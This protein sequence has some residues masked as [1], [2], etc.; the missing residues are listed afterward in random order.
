MIKCDFM[1]GREHF[2][3]GRDDADIT[4]LFAGRE[5]CGPGKSCRGSRSHYLLHY[6]LRGQG[7]VGHACGNRRILQR[8]DLFLYAP[9]DSLDY[10]A[11]D[12]DPW[13]YTWVGFSGIRCNRVI[14][15]CSMYS[16]G[17]QQV[18]RSDRSWTLQRLFEEISIVLER[19]RPGY[20]YAADGLLLQLFGTLA[21]TGHGE[22]QERRWTPMNWAE[23]IRRFID[24]NFEKPIRVATVTRSVGLD[25]SYASRIFRRHYNET[26]QRYL[27]RRRMERAATLLREGALTVTEVAH[28]VGYDQY[29]GFERC[30][31]R[32]TG[33]SPGEF[34]NAVIHTT[35]RAPVRDSWEVP[36]PKV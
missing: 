22:T 25:R 17:S 1:S 31:R 18:I 13:E 4:V 5:A 29:A 19:R 8:G 24:A 9:G 12:H 11:S 10:R 26:I 20:Q 23:E 32:E 28:S 2:A 33:S 7:S 30:F 15:R 34:R 27:I 6:V 35:W 16:D 3:T 36:Y 21:E 14:A